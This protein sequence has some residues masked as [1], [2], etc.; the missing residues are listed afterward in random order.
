MCIAAGLTLDSRK[1][2]FSALELNNV[3]QVIFYCEFAFLVVFIFYV[4]IG[5]VS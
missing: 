4:N 1:A 2:F 3:C 5:S